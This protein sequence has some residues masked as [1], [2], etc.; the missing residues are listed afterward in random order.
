MALPK[1]E[2]PDE[3][4]LVLCTVTKIYPHSVFVT[5][6][7]Y[8]N[9]QGMIHISEIAPG[10]IRNIHDYVK[11]GKKIVCKVLQINRERGHIDLSL[12]RVSEGQK[13]EK[14]EQIK[15]EQKAQKIVEFVADKLKI[16]KVALYEDMQKK[17][18][19]I[20]GTLHDVFEEFITDETTL[21]GFN[22]Q[23]NIYDLLAE[24]IRQRI[25]PP[26]VM[27]E[28]EIKLK[29]YAPNGL[30]VIKKILAGAAKTSDTM[31]LRYKGG[32]SYSMDIKDSNFKDA[33]KTM[34]NASE[35]IEK[36]AKKLDCEF[37]FQRLEKKQAKKADA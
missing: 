10:R 20:Y 11:M 32:G 30:D 21:R 13:R 1:K 2:L 4:E 22:L 15:K 28:G 7:D 17:L 37:S 35:F 16:D 9:K 8:D 36:E 34:A 19:E 29:S 12:R 24:T 26:E 31:K 5:I 6:D 18:P 23:K 27:I 33:E 25:K 14:A 3:T